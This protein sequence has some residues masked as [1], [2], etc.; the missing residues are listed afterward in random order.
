M[1]T[2]PAEKHSTVVAWQTV[3]VMRRSVSGPAA[4]SMLMVKLLATLLNSTRCTLA[5]RTLNRRV[6]GPSFARSDGSRPVA[7]GLNRIRG[8]SAGY[9]TQIQVA[10]S[11]RASIFGDWYCHMQAICMSIGAWHTQVI[12]STT[13][14]RTSLLVGNVTRQ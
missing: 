7:L 13:A 14:G 9:F 11:L 2:T 6:H 8:N 10:P 5:P 12:R 1:E 3:K 4:R